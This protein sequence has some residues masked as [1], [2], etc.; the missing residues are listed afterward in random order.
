MRT[1]GNS[2]DGTVELVKNQL[3]VNIKPETDQVPRPVLIIAIGNFVKYDTWYNTRSALA[4]K[5]RSG[6]FI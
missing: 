4:I 3:S 2:L 1:L 6:R 5:R